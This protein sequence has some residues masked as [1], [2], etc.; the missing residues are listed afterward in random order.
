MV[1]PIRRT[2]MGEERLFCFSLRVLSDAS[3]KFGGMDNIF[4]AIDGADGINAV[5]WLAARMMEAG[6]RYAVQHSMDDPAPVNEDAILDGLDVTEF[7]A[8]KGI[9]FDTIN[10]DSEA[11]VTVQAEENPTEA[12]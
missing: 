7:G 8:L 2:L 4:N 6:H 11:E 9:I 10:N 1:K 3:A 5:A 12:R